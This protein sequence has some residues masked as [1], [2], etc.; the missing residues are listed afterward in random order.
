MPQDAVWMAGDEAV[1]S[2]C[3]DEMSI[4][5]EQDENQPEQTVAEEQQTWTIESLKTGF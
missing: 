2:G 4:R 5:P 3:L 1:G